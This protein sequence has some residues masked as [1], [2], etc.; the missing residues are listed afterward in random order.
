[1]KLA[2]YQ[3]SIQNVKR[4][5]ICEHACMCVCKTKEEEK[6]IRKKNQKGQ[7]S[8]SLLNSINL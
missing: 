4:V 7:T 5:D 1:M 6:C 8:L 3:Q 2:S